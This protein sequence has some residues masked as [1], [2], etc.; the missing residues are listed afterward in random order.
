MVESLHLEHL[1]LN[2]EITWDKNFRV[3]R[4]I[5]NLLM[6]V[7]FMDRLTD[8]E[9]TI[10][11]KIVYL[12]GLLTLSQLKRLVIRL[13]LHCGDVVLD[14]LVSLFDR[15]RLN[16]VVVHLFCGLNDRCVRNGRRIDFIKEKLSV[17]VG[18]RIVYGNEIFPHC[19]CLRKKE[20]KKNHSDHLNINK[21]IPF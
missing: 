6:R 13:E 1:I 4:F 2:F 17:A 7:D 11:G 15:L 21:L 8:L 5:D 18:I 10:G 19:C 3:R 12:N 9:V 14:R 16:Q 20:N